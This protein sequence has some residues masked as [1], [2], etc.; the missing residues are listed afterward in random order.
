MSM[1][2]MEIT[3]Q[4]VVDR[5]QRLLSGVPDGID[6]A[7]QSAMNRTV[8]YIRTNSVRAI[9][10]RY[11]ISAGNL[12]ANQNVTVR[13]MHSNGVQAIITFRGQKI[14]LWRYDGASPK[15]PARTAD[16]VR[17]RVK[18]Q[19]KTVHPGVAAAGHQLKSTGPKRFGTAFVATMKSGHTGIFR[20][21]GGMT[22]TGGEELKE[23]MG[24]SF[25]QMIGNEEV[26]EKVSKEAGDKFEERL[27]HEILRILNGWGG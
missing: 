24:S 27:E 11:A 23:I 17:T 1:I 9:R 12:R 18:G 10:Q 26:L 15:G 25:P 8:S 3:G 4:E 7:V 13:Y 21:T 22:S 19:W 6:R 20:R 14:P 5:A 2:R 16:L